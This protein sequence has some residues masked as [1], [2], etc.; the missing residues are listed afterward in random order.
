MRR[1]RAPEKGEVLTWT[2]LRPEVFIVV[3]FFFFSF[4]LSF[5][6]DINIIVSVLRSRPAEAALLRHNA[7][8]AHTYA[9][10]YMYLYTADDTTAAAFSLS[11]AT[12]GGGEIV[13]LSA[14]THLVSVDPYP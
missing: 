12:A 8:R 2:R 1:T 9:A 13:N 4:F 3:F 5:P 14:E 6:L 11:R 10:A 7:Q